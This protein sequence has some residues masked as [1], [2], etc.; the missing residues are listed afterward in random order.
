MK[1]TRR[2]K[3]FLLIFIVVITTL[4][5]F[6]NSA[7]AAINDLYVGDYE[8]NADNLDKSLSDSTLI[9]LIARCVYWLARLLEWLMGIIF[10]LLTNSSDFPWADKI[11]FNTVPL[12]DINFMNPA[13]GSFVGVEGVQVVIKN[14]YTSILSI[15][16]AFFGIVVLITAIKLVLT[17]IATEKAKY[18]QAIVDWLVGFVTLFCIHYA[19]AFI[20]YLNEQLVTVASSIVMEQ[21]DAAE[22]VAQ[23]RWEG[24]LGTLYDNAVASGATYNGKPVSKIMNDNAYITMVYSNDDLVNK[25]DTTKG[26]Y[27]GLTRDM[28]WL[29][30]WD[31][32]V[33]D[34]KLYERLGMLI[35]W[36][37]D[38]NISKSELEA[39]KV[40]LVVEYDD[41]NG[42]YY[43]NQALSEDDLIDMFP[44][45]DMRE[46]FLEAFGV[47][48]DDHKVYGMKFPTNELAVLKY[49]DDY[50]QSLITTAVDGKKYYRMP[51]LK[52][53]L[54]NPP[55]IG[56]MVDSSNKKIYYLSSGTDGFEVRNWFWDILVP[57]Y[58]RYDDGWTNT[59][60]NFYWTDVLKDLITLKGASDTAGQSLN[61]QNGGNATQV[62]SEKYRL[63]SNLATYFRENAFD[64]KET[65]GGTGLKKGD[66][67]KIQN[68]LMYAVLVAQSLILFIAY[69]KRL[70]YV[71]ILALMSPIVVVFDFFQKFGK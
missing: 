49:I 26:V 65:H 4:L 2:K 70:F 64:W 58:G 59:K 20:F 13:K 30:W 11:V 9:K 39:I 1:V 19:I 15:A 17:T 33:G 51:G 50:P 52:F 7:F 35:Q 3:T 61:N 60:T 57:G 45:E 18:K 14:I 53:P 12:L 32:K 37:A 8:T 38:V 27:Q 44:D 10:K 21:L 5:F 16:V 66:N 28:G 43:M 40:K 31:W 29:N 6:N 36:A 48:D 62:L 71:V 46:R 24:S 22:D 42:A 25:K 34:K 55:T 63:I 56:D 54:T 68:M 23:T 47:T 67:P 69:I 41:Y